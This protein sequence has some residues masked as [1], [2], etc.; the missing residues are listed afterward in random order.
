V[1]AAELRPCEVVGIRALE[2]EKPCGVGA[3][4]MAEGGRRGGQRLGG[5]ITSI[6]GFF[7]QLTLH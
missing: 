2:R 4:V 7:L 3:A 6:G 5:D 1:H